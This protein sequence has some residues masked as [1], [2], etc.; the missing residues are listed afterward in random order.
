[1]KRLGRLMSFIGSTTLTVWLVGLFIVYYLSMA[2]WS[3]EA[4]ATYITH[5]S[6]NNLFRIFYI[7]FFLNVTARIFSAF[8][9]LWSSKIRFFLRLPL[10][11]GLVVFLFSFFMSLNI[12]EY[13]WLIV[14][15]G[16][17][18]ELPHELGLLRIVRVESALKKR[19]L[20]TE[21]AVIFDYEPKVV[22]QDERGE[23]HT[24]GAFP[25]R[26]VSGTW[27][28]ILNFGIGPGV[29]LRRDGEALFKGEI[30]L[31]LT[32]FGS[33]DS[34]R[35]EPFPYKFYVSILPNRI[36]RKGKEAGR[37][38]DLSAPRYQVAVAKGDKMIAKG[39]T[40][41]ELMFDGDMSLKF[42]PPSD[43]VALDIAHDPFYPWFVS[44][45]LLLLIGVV[46]YPFSFFS[47][48]RG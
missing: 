35:I 16:D 29:E 23:R 1:M 42:F 7:I 15:E 12:R 32:P 31:R 47:K 11:A 34:F 2:V 25:P 10:Y 5:L 24:I 39:E 41:A 27:M 9:A 14:G 3:K 38:Y 17:V 4:F 43:W 21:E 45:L 46:L 6:R 22:L 20:R 28:H 13:K 33:V 36:V 30:A 37:D 19:A 40:D 18:V 8:R 48:K 26:L 44:G